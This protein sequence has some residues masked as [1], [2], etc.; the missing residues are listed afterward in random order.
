M[1][2]SILEPGKPYFTPCQV[3]LYVGDMW[4]DDAVDVQ[5]EVRDEKTPAYGFA[6]YNYRAALRGRSVVSG[7]LVINFRFTGYLTNAIYQATS[8][9]GGFQDYRDSTARSY[10][11]ALTAP[12]L[13]VSKDELTALG[14]LAVDSPKAF[15]D[16]KKELRERFHPEHRSANLP[17]TLGERPGLLSTTGL[18][19]NKTINIFVAYGDDAYGDNPLY[20]QTIKDVQFTGQSQSISNLGGQGDQPVLE[21][22]PFFAKSID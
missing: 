19:A 22:Y 9:T 8:P 3:S 2:S 12:Y 11:R 4:I 10:Q 14:R 1:A 15:E 20:Y 6:D 17:G 5:W 13:S 7:S 18:A 16:M 21:A